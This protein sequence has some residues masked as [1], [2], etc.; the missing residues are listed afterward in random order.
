[1][2]DQQFSAIGSCT[3]GHI[4]FAMK[5]HPLVVHCCHCTWCQRETGSAFVLNALIETH[6]IELRKGAPEP[7]STPSN[8]GKGQIIVRCAHCQVALWS[9]YRGLGEAIAFVRVGVLEP[10]HQLEPSVHI[11]TSTKVPWLDLGDKVPVYE[12]YYRRS[13]VWADDSISRYKK[14]LGKS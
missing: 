4:Q 8:S 1:M 5:H 13:E 2:G 11:F 7:V 14:A 6:Q 9:H 10:G 12:E 3:C